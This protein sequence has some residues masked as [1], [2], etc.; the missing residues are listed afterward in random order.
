MLE[1]A[2]WLPNMK[3]KY[4]IT[5]I[6][7]K[8]FGLALIYYQV[9]NAIIKIHTSSVPSTRVTQKCHNTNDNYN[10]NQLELP[11]NTMI[12]MVNYYSTKEEIPTMNESL[13][14]DVVILFWRTFISDSCKE[15]ITCHL[16]LL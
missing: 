5:T 16:S 8:K 12:L 15:E 2:K 4:W 1:Y 9:Y 3:S 13:H 6:I 7:K 10:N 14:I 11:K